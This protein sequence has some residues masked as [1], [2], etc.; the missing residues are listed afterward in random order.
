MCLRVKDGE[1]IRTATEDMV[2]YKRLYTSNVSPFRDFQY[3]PYKEEFLPFPQTLQLE[4]YSRAMRVHK[5]FHFSLKPI[6]MKNVF[7]Y[8]IVQMTIP[9]GAHYVLGTWDEIVADRVLPGSLESY[10]G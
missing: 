6:V 5:G 10:S 1:T 4:F 7:P 2:V 8:K 9:K 3:T